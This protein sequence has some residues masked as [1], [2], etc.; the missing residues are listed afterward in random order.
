MSGAAKILVMALLTGVLGLGAALTPAGLRLEEHFGLEWLFRLRGVRTAPEDVVIVN[1]ED[2]ATED[3]S[4]RGSPQK[5]PRSLFA[6]ITRNLHRQGAAVVAFDMV[7]DEPRSAA[8][9]TQFAQAVQDSRKVVLC[10]YLKRRTIQLARDSGTRSPELTMEGLV[11]PIAPLAESAAALAPFVLPKVPARVSRCWTFSA[12][13]GESS[14]LPVVA[15]QIF[16]LDVQE[17]FL[18]LLARV[19]PTRVGELPGD[20]DRLL[21]THRVQE[22]VHRLRGFFLEDPRLGERLLAE[23]ENPSFPDLSP[24]KSRIL[25]SLIQMYRGPGSL[26]LNYYGPT[27]TVRHVSYQQLLR[28]E[29]LGAGNPDTLD[30]RGKLVLVGL[31]ETT[32]TEQ[33]DGFQTVFS[34]RQGIYI[35]G[36]EIAA[37]AVANLLE[38]LPVRPLG[39]AAHAAV[40]FAWGVGMGGLCR[41]LSTRS[42][43]LGSAGLMVLYLLFARSRFRDAAAWYPLAVPLLIQSPFAFL[44]STFWRHSDTHRERQHMKK[45]LSYY[46]PRDAVE[47]I[48]V[49][50]AD[51]ERRSQVLYAVCLCTDAAKY[52]TLSETMD[53]QDLQ[54]L[55]NRYY[56]TLFQPVAEQEGAVANVVGDS[57]LAIWA[58]TQP[59]SLQRA[60]ACDAA[61]GIAALMDPLAGPG[62]RVRLPT[63]IGIHFGL[64]SL[65][66]VGGKGR[67]EYRPVGDCV[68]T[69]SRIEGLNKYLGTEILASQEALDGV[70]GF[71]TREVG[72]FL[73]AGKAKSLVLHQLLCR[74]ENSTPDRELLCSTFA[75]G[76]AAY[77]EGAVEPAMGRFE[78]CLE[79][80]E[81]DG[82]SLFYLRLCREFFETPPEGTWTGVVVLGKK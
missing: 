19:A 23:L 52:T 56:E 78:R 37:T 35:S 55:L 3:L 30:L 42:A 70:D 20:K 7:F 79:I 41:A 12:G 74:R 18:R 68:N 76:L 67:Y 63:R 44:A 29:D 71:L 27:G 9:D 11:D 69:S 26:Y 46:L 64:V 14:S 21:D 5:W 61:L 40:V 47:Q 16:A 50:M 73:L 33:K 32:S 2:A 4:V 72:E 54:G 77:R 22:Y 39:P 36:V 28:A 1:M 81:N 24:E 49:H 65:G 45:A 15:F 51:M 53:P 58:Q 10:R 43:A 75:Q 66:N 57:M 34:T 62:S 25:R 13:A 17:D 31:S 8:E 38:D 82:P 59:D 80:L 6:G 48:V 60:R